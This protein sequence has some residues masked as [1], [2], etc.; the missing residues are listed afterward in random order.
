MNHKEEK[1]KMAVTSSN[2]GIFYS[3]S[4][5]VGH[6]THGKDVGYPS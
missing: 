6:Q 4:L 3:I 5:D 2:L 1:K